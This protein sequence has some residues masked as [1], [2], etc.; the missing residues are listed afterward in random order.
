MQQVQ[1]ALQQQFDKM[2]KT[3]RLYRSI[4]SGKDV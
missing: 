3:G 4:V 1:K 2:C